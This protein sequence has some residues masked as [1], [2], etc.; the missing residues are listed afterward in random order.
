MPTSGD[1]TTPQLL[2]AALEDL[3]SLRIS[4]HLAAHARMSLPSSVSTVSGDSGDDEDP[5]NTA[6]ASGDNEVPVDSMA[7]QLPTAPSLGATADNL[8]KPAYQAGEPFKTN[9][10]PTLFSLGPIRFGERTINAHA[11]AP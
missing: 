1:P 8:S 11:Q 6:I 3:C 10:T 7:A 5:A 2:S 4:L 9:W